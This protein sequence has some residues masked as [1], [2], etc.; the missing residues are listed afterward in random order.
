MQERS[1]TREAAEPNV[2]QEEAIDEHYEHGREGK[3]QR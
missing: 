3:V 2:S 1:R